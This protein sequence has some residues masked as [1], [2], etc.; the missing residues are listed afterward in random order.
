MVKQ[1]RDP[2]ASSGRNGVREQEYGHGEALYDSSGRNEKKPYRYSTRK[3]QSPTIGKE[4]NAHTEISF[5][6]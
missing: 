5:I 4:R 6:G 3:Q 2:R 1:H